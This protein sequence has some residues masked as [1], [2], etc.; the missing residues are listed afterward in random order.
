MDIR[1]T[2]EAAQN[3]GTFVHLTLDS[4]GHDG[5]VLAVGPDLV[6]IQAVHEWQDVGALVVPVDLIENCEVSDYA[7]AQLKILDF[8]SVKRTKRY[9]WVRLGSFPE[10]F[11]SLKFKEK[12][13]VAS[14]ADSADVGLVDVV[15]DDCVV[16][17]S[18]DPGGAWQEDEVEWPYE[19]I[20]LIQFD[21]SY[22]RVLQRYV[23]KN[24][25][26]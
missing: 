10:L 14:A 17:K 4:G 25:T 21:D 5:F 8:N 19:D 18:V 22:S 1:K 12:F 23:E 2:L 26:N 3:L 9:S 7:D 13:V 16:L 24:A 6:L 11:R 15:E 20:T